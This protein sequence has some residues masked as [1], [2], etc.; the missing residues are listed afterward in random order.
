MLFFPDRHNPEGEF[1]SRGIKIFS[2]V[3][4]QQHKAMTTANSVATV[5]SGHVKLDTASGT[6]AAEARHAQCLSICVT[7]ELAVSVLGFFSLKTIIKAK[8][9]LC[10]I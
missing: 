9:N 5:N 4:Q 3:H 7:K 10:V 1:S 2:P 6:Q 8:Q